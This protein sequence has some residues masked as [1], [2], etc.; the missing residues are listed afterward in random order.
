MRK[1]PP[2]DENAPTPATPDPPPGRATPMMA[3]YMEIKSRYAD[4][5]LLFRMGD[6][7]EMFHEDAHLASRLLGLT[8]TSRDRGPSDGVPLA[9]LPWHSAE[10]Y[11]AKLLKAGHKV[12]ICEQV[13]D[14]P[15]KNGLMDRRVVE[16]LTP[17]TALQDGL[18]ESGA[19][20]FVAAVRL[21][22][23]RVG[24]A[25][26]DISTGEFLVGEADPAEAATQIARLQPS[27]LLVGSDQ[28]ESAGLNGILELMAGQPFL[29]PVDGW[30]FDAGRAAR[31]LKEHFRLATLGGWDL[32]DLRPGLAAAGA[33]LEYAREQKQSDLAHVR[34]LQRIR[35][36]ATMVLDVM[37]LR[38][39]EVL[40]PL[41][42]TDRST[43]L[44]HAVDGTL[45]PMGSRR[46]RGA[47]RAPL[48]DLAAIRRRH[49]VIGR[50]AASVP[51]LARLRKSL[52]GIRDLERLLGKVTTERETPRDL[53]ALRESLRVLP[54]LR[55][56]VEELEDRG[57]PGSGLDTVG[58][59]LEIL[60]RALVDDPPATVHDIGVFREGFDEGMDAIRKAAVDGRRWI[61]SLQE[62]ERA[63]TGIA[64]LKVGFNRVFGYYLEVTRPHLS[65]VPDH[66]LRKQTLVNAE[67]YVTPELK[68]RE[69]K[70]LGAE[71]G[72]KARQKDLLAAL[73]ADVGSRAV[74]LLAAAADVAELDLLAG[75]ADVALR[76][77]FNRPRMTDVSEI[78]VLEG[79][80][81][82]VETFLPAGDFVAN[83]VH[84]DREER[85]VQI[86]TG[87]NMA[88]KST[89]L[90]QVG[91]LSLLAQA[92]SWIPAKEATLGLVDRIFTRVGASDNIALGQSTFLVEMV[93]TSRILH[94]ATP[95]SLVLLDEIGRGTSTYD[96]LSIAWAVA[97]SLGR[98]MG[99]RPMVIFA[100]HFHELTGLAREKRGF[101]NLNVLVREW[102]DEV[103]FLR[104]VADGAADRSYGIHVARLAGVPGPVLERAKEILARLES[105]GPG[106]AP[107]GALDERQL[108]LF[109]E[110]PGGGADPPPGAS[111]GPPAS[112]DPLRAEIRA[113]DLDGL[114]PREAWTWIEERKRRLGDGPAAGAG[115]SGG[116]PGRA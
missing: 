47:L 101:L 54:V 21:E 107:A 22:G 44:V 4:A 98:P 17:G 38:H 76:R 55:G 84:L 45:T 103:V 83:D 74:R 48:M 112:E 57:V 23:D 46:L 5:V 71:E 53:A 36:G 96:G 60:E 3:Q 26:A 13:S 8:L 65:K 64:S 68:A 28:I 19:N 18:L 16:V 12:A 90:R 10:P 41:L 50:L 20:N 43:T 37:T 58:D 78:H 67:R 82:V 49:E 72:E 88:G 32:D 69:E 105:R 104:R 24:F 59:L 52:A 75:W 115:E 14:A 66:Y 111:K 61:A 93:E 108:G 40:E 81:P 42:G 39:L 79:R 35:T 11:I 109:E 97:E 114:S 102:N 31:R 56:Q 25:A 51:H 116:D 87:P 94:Q 106:R 15:A 63:S 73:R 9:G 70:I 80:H 29:T 110:A 92:G 2:V 34:S 113:L 91:L 86:L 100:T 7:Y 77:G 6:F 33:L 95:R 1:G 30:R 89:F 27:E 85:Q 62:S 99:P